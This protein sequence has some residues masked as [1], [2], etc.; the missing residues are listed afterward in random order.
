MNAENSY[1]WNSFP[2]TILYVYGIVF[3]RTK[4]IKGEGGDYY[5][6]TLR[7]CLPQGRKYLTY[8]YLGAS[9]IGIR[10]ECDFPNG[11]VGNYGDEF[12]SYNRTRYLQRIF[13]GIKHLYAILILIQIPY[14]TR[15]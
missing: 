14:K 3:A 2:C 12:F 1:L 6:Y 5:C 7:I 8:K 9:Y 15:L 11:E 4:R 10:V 13:H